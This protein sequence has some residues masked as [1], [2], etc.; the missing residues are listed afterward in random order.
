MP[1]QDWMIFTLLAFVLPAVSSAQHPKEPDKVVKI[2]LLIPDNKSLAAEY[3]AELAVQKAN[4]KGGFNGLPFRLVVRSMEG[5]WGTGSKEAVN[6]IFEDNVWAI[7][8]S[9]DGRNAHL[10]EQAATKARI[11]FLSAWTSDPTLSQAFVPWYFSCVPNDLQQADALINEIYFERK[12]NRIAIVSDN[13][14]DSGLALKSFLKKAAMAGME[15][16]LKFFY[17]NNDQNFRD[18]TNKLNKAD[19]NCIIFLGRP[20]PL[21]KIIGQMRLEK[22]SQPM[23]CSLGALDENQLSSEVLRNYEN[24]VFVSS[25]NWSGHNGLSFNEWFREKYGRLPGAVAAYAF[26]GMNIIIEAIRKAGTDRDKIRE[27]ISGIKFE[28][29]TGSIR[30]DSKGNRLGTPILM[31]IKNGTPVDVERE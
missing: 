8:G 14:Y 4:E 13:G 22:M 27:S 10:V 17:D 31:K 5:P 29:V 20:S 15:D 12:I 9:H 19:I 25:G 7:M 18:L 16:P 1:F 26:D 6:L 24:V 28:G 2:G 11:V 3:G 30:F 21:F 23:Y